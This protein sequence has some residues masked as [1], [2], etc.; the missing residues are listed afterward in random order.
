MHFDPWNPRNI[1][2]EITIGHIADLAAYT[3][4]GQMAIILAATLARL[5]QGPKRQ[6]VSALSPASSQAPA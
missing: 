5:Q 6:E 4:A 2:E 1:M 3:T